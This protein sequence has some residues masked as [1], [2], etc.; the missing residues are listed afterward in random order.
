MASGEDQMDESDEL[1]DEEAWNEN[2]MF[3]SPSLCLFCDHSASKIESLISHCQLIH[4]FSFEYLMKRFCM[5]CYS[6][7][8]FVNYVRKT[9]PSPEK[10]LDLETV[11][12]DDNEYLK[13]VEEFD[14]WLMFGKSKSN[15]NI[16][17]K[18]IE[19]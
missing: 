11:Q 3:E 6:F 16:C 14:P 19:N 2:E 18:I 12:W 7:I 9:S 8:K 5:D 1:S 17:E 15:M 4:N 13:P 10:I